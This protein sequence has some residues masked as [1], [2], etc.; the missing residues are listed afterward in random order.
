VSSVPSVD[1]GTDDRRG[2]IAG[3][4]V[5]KSN[6]TS[7]TSP[8]PLRL[9]SCFG[10]KSLR[11]PGR[12]S[13]KTAIFALQFLGHLCLHQRERRRRAGISGVVSGAFMSPDALQFVHRSLGHRAKRSQILDQ[14]FADV[15][16]RLLRRNPVLNQDGDEF[17]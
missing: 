5:F 6:P 2:S 17:C 13:S 1:Q 7:G 4:R 8:R 16:G 15:R 10:Q 3:G 14:L 11:W 9:F 12:V